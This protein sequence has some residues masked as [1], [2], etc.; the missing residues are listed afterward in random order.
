MVRLVRAANRLASIKTVAAF[1]ELFNSAYWASRTYRGM[2]QHL[3]PA[4]TAL[5]EY[6]TQDDRNG[7]FRRLASRLRVDA[8]KLHRLL[9]LI[10]DEEAFPGREQVRREIGVLQSL[11]L[12]L[13]QH[14]FLKVV[15]IP[16][17]A[18]ANDISRA[19]VIEMVLTLRVEDALEQLR[20]AYPAQSAQTGDFQLSEPGEYPDGGTE[21]FGAIHRDYIDRIECAHQLNLRIGVAIANLFG[22]PLERYGES[23]ATQLLHGKLDAV[24]G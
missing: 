10:P 16:A 5:A 6:L 18:R 22:A 24:H 2:E 7:V 1:G 20:R 15:S 21:G 12:A 14:M 19:D 9:A 11:R 8:L 17:F 4:C 3:A 13:L 23:K